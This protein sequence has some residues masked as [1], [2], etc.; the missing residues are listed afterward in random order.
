MTVPLVVLAVLSFV[1]GW[2]GIPAVLT[3]GSGLERAARA[4]SRRGQPA[5][6][7]PRARSRERTARPW[8]T[9]GPARADADRGG[10]GARRRRDR[11]RLARVPQRGARG[12]D[13]ARRSA[14]STDC[15]ATCTGS[16]SCTRR[17]IVRPFYALSP[18]LRGLRPLGRRRPGQRDGGRG[19]HHRADHQAVPDRA[20]PQLRADVPRSV[21]SPSSYYL[22]RWPE[23]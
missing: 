23:R 4:G 13:R 16:T 14:R 21:S 8:P 19:R 22:A 12:A 10:A 6:G 5:R 15:C 2:I 7:G 20:R 18:V 1:G 9:R 17:S 3:G 11:P